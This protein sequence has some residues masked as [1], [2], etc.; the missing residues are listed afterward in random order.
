VL[1]KKP[2]KFFAS[3]RAENLHTFRFLF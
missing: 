3:K 1:V 2:P